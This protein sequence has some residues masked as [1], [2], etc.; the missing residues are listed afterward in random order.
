MQLR[1]KCGGEICIMS[2]VGI[3]KIGRSFYFKL[4]VDWR[5]EQG[6]DR[7]SLVNWRELEDGSIIISP[8]QV[9]R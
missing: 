9:V 7:G 2:A 1:C 6:I 5:K 8:K 4:P 3:L